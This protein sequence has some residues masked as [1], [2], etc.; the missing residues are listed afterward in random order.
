MAWVNV[1]VELSEFSDSEL[2]AEMTTRGFLV[3]EDGKDKYE[4]ES[5]WQ[6]LYELLALGK[7]DEA[8]ELVQRMVQNETGRVL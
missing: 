5:E 2:K 3:F 6:R 4:R 1:E 8:L 7:K